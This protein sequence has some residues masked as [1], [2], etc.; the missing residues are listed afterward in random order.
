MLHFLKGRWN[1]IKKQVRKILHFS[2]GSSLAGANLSKA[3]FAWEKEKGLQINH[4]ICEMEGIQI[5][6]NHWIWE[7]DKSVINQLSS[8]WDGGKTKINH[9]YWRSAYYKSI[10]T[11]AETIFRRICFLFSPNIIGRTYILVASWIKLKGKAT[12]QL[13]WQLLYSI[14]QCNLQVSLQSISQ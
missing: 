1:R 6:I 5:Q 11:Q 2:S 9:Q 4:Q 7:K 3:P 12:S 10:V 8:S 14:P 13:D